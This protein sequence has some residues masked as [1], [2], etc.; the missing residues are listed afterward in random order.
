ML[1]VDVLLLTAAPVIV[2]F[3]TVLNEERT[4]PEIE[5]DVVQGAVRETTLVTLHVTVPLETVIVASTGA[6]MVSETTPVEFARAALG[7]ARIAKMIA[8]AAAGREPTG[9]VK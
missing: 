8:R 4:L 6:L 2:T 1:L 3:V 9:E 7:H 5:A